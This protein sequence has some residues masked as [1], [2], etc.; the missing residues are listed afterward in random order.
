MAHLDKR[1]FHYAW[2]IL[3][4]A[5]V[6]NIVARADQASFG[7]FIDP[8][9]ER[10]GWKRGDI[11]FA[12]SLAFL[13]GIPALVVMGWLGDRFGARLLMLIAA[14]MIGTGTVLLGAIEELWH[15]YLIYGIFVG[16]TG[17]AAFSV[18]LPVI[19][20]RWF[21]RHLG[22]VM[23]VYWAG[24]GIGP[25]IFA[26]LFRWLIETQG[27]QH[28]FMTIGLALGLIL[29][30]FSLFIY[31]SPATKGLQPYGV[32]DAGTRP[33][34]STPSTP[35]PVSLRQVLRLRNVWHLT[36]VHHIG[37]L[38]HAIILAHVVS[39]ATFK[40]IPGVEAAGVLAAIAGSSV[41]SRVAFSLIAD[42]FGGRITLTLA[43]LG[44]T[45]PVI[46]L[47]FASEPWMF[48]LFAI[49]FGLSYGGEM[50]GFP[51]INKQLFGTKAPL[52]SIYSFEMVGAGI[53][54]AIGAWLG[55]SLFDLT[56]DYTWSLTISLVAGTIGVPLALAL[57]R[58]K[59]PPPAT[60]PVPA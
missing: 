49:V 27:W 16:S 41:I 15:F 10:F 51:I 50:V 20:T 19:M 11:S 53:G 21:H 44:Q 36:A 24:Q 47:F 37:C 34:P 59:A 58:H 25:V 30:V 43:L 6:L 52:S 2:V 7:V 35:A 38:S 26:P 48:Y 39:M 31:N 32:E 56:G 3:A 60:I 14:V 42:R 23:G 12:Y 57:P 13:I 1:G 46:I 17:H 55:G 28:T 8:L 22:I 4:A 9:V 29:G 33:G 5:C 18:L 54:M 45:L 40:G